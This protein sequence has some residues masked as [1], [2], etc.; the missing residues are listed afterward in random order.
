MKRSSTV[1]D[2]MPDPPDI[3][4][5]CSLTNINCTIYNL[6]LYFV[7]NS[8]TR[9]PRSSKV[10]FMRVLKHTT[11]YYIKLY[12]CN[13]MYYSISYNVKNIEI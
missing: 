11:I 8:F 9:R 10:I 13:Y 4:Y 6:Y 12:I 1:A 3:N 2:K 7:P 5:E